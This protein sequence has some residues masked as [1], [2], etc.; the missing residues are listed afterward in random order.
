LFPKEKKLIDELASRIRHIC[1]LDEG[2][3]LAPDFEH[4]TI[5]VNRIDMADVLAV[6]TAAVDIRIDECRDC[7]VIRGQSL[8]GE[9]LDVAA[10]PKL[11]AN[12]M[13]LIEAWRV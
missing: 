8:D 5:A 1:S 12:T 3:E 11:V 7:V 2:I 4:N 10:Q 9:L 6:V 13:T